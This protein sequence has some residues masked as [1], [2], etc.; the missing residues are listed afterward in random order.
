MSLDLD[1]VS[2]IMYLHQGEVKPGD[3]VKVVRY[4][5]KL[6]DWKRNV[7]D[8][9]N[10]KPTTEDMSA[11]MIQLQNNFDGYWWEGEKCGCERTHWVI[12]ASETNC[13]DCMHDQCTCNPPLVSDEEEKAYYRIYLSCNGKTKK[14]SWMTKPIGTIAEINY[15]QGEE[16]RKERREKKREEEKCAD[17]H[18][19]AQIYG[20]CCHQHAKVARTEQE[21]REK[22]KEEAKE[23]GKQNGRWTRPLHP[24]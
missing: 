11:N 9:D 3:E 10:N 22:T 21:K 17:Y 4:K 19:S 1:V 12:H 15:K 18:Q 20:Y 7:I 24:L 23:W 16:N 6:Y 8:G 13:W 14:N 2:Q 5:S